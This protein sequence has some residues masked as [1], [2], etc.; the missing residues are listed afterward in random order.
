[1]SAGEGRVRLVDIV[2][3]EGAYSLWVGNRDERCALYHPRN[4]GR[5]LGSALHGGTEYSQA[6]CHLQSEVPLP[7]RLM[8]QRVRPKLDDIVLASSQDI[9]RVLLCIEHFSLLFLLSISFIVH[10]DC[11][12]RPVLC[13]SGSVQ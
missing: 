5:I 12:T 9:R 8:N 13:V 2:R 7:Q 1:M 10:H 11:M 4:W 6:R 3:A